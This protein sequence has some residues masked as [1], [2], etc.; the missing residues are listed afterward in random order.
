[1]NIFVI[2]AGVSCRCISGWRQYRGRGQHAEVEQEMED[3]TDDGDDYE[4]AA[5]H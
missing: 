1:M 5:Q 2:G 4:D 3:A